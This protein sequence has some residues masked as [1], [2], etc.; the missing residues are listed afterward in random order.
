MTFQITA[1]VTAHREGLI[2]GASLHSFLDSVAIA[3]QEGIKVEKVVFLDNADETT[4]TVFDD[5]DKH[6]CVV[7]EVSYSDQGLVRNQAVLQA[8]GEYI[9]FL[10][11]DDLWSEN[12]LLK[13]F[14]FCQQNM[15][16]VIAH[17]EFNWFFEGNNNLYVKVDQLSSE[18]DPVFLRFAN[19]WD[20]LCLTSK[21]VFNRFPYC[22][23][24]VKEGFAYED[25]Y[26][27]KKTVEAGYIHRIV[28]NTIHFKRRRSASQTIDASK[29]MC[30]VDKT[31]L[32]KYSF[33][34]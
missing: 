16:N 11:G 33:Y 26:W 22:K 25:W 5:A 28:P 9:A 1:I 7:H 13:A 10:D 6:G 8:K 29:N 31:D 30:L 20:A 12:W 2:A 17:P 15:N 23:R 4:K 21:E 24:R 34:V 14:Q 3:E 18:Y 19:Y 27:N 32:N